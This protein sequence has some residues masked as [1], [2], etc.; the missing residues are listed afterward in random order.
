MADNSESVG[1]DCCK[2]IDFRCGVCGLFWPSTYTDI[3][4]LLNGGRLSVIS[5]R[6]Q[7]DLLLK[8]LER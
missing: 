6:R 8:N 7:C 3:F 2:F 1:D 4:R 5:V